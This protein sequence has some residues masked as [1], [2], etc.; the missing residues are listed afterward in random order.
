MHLLLSRGT[1]NDHLSQRYHPEVSVNTDPTY[2]QTNGEPTLGVV[3]LMWRM[4][5]FSIESCGHFT[6][7][8]HSDGSNRHTTSNRSLSRTFIHHGPLL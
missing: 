6:A 1:A 2:D 3:G 8:S 4:F 5:L 7:V